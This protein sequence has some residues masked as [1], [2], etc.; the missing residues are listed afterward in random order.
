VTLRSTV[1]P[2]GLSDSVIGTVGLVPR[3]TVRTNVLVFS[4]AGGTVVSARRDERAI[5]IGTGRERGRQV[6]VV[7]VDLTPGAG[8]TLDFDLLTGVPPPGVSGAFRPHLWTTPGV[9][10]WTVSADSAEFCQ[11]PG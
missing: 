11:Q 9:K 4:P 8:V 1:P 5:G 6:G 3:Y 10:R 7:T 2:S